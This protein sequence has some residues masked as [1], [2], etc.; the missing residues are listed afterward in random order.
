MNRRQMAGLLLVVGMTV[1]IGAWGWSATRDVF[2]HPRHEALFPTCDGCH[3]ATPEGVTK[4]EP[5]FCAG[6]HNGQT[7][8]TVDWSPTDRISNLNFNHA[9]V[10][11]AKREA[12]GGEFPCV[13][14]HQQPGGNRMDVVIPAPEMCYGC[15]EPGRQHRVEGACE[16]CHVVQGPTTIFA[17]RPPASHTMTFRENHKAAA[18]ANTAECQNCHVQ[19]QCTGCH[20][21]SEA[22]A[23]PVHD[24]DR[25]HPLN[26]I[27]QHSA[28]AFSR[29][30]ECATCHNPE[31]FCRDCHSARGL[32]AEF[33]PE[34]GFH[35][36]KQ[37]FEFGHGQAARLGLESCVTCHAQSDCLVCH[38]ATSGRMVNPHGPD[39]DPRKL[40]SKS[41]ATCLVCHTSEILNR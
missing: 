23:T 4:P 5:S 7:V 17:R 32:S 2:P 9:T 37:L 19:D 33:R 18:A 8:R 41:P 1:G 3:Q 34:T 27:Q 29:E 40:R 28:P 11:A 14:C 25:Y 6:C 38:S 30:V 15:H 21:G 16:T 20:T 39:F 24:V 31:A 36:R 13:A 10:L 22:V 35:N 12:L 26:Y